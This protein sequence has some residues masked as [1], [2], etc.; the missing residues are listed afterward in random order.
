MAFAFGLI[1]RFSFASGLSDLGLLQ[2]TLILVLVGFNPG[3]EAGRL[4]IVAVFLPLAFMLRYTAIYRH[5]VLRC[6]SWLIAALAMFARRACVRHDPAAILGFS[7]VRRPTLHAIP[8][9]LAGAFP[10]KT[11][12][13]L[14]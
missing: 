8:P 5:L 11:A 4:A 9:A 10:A 2:D 3:V 1:H 7:P 6:C 12:R 13:P 14:F